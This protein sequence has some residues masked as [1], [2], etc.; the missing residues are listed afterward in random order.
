MTAT[1]ISPIGLVKSIN[2]LLTVL[3]MVNKD[4]KT[5]IIAV[6]PVISF[7]INPI[8]NRRTPANPVVAAV[9]AANIAIFFFDD[10]DKLLIHSASFVCH[11]VAFLII[12]ISAV[13]N[14]I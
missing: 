10:S 7:G 2:A 9:I 8:N 11:S 14:A 1:T 4:V 5:L 3:T 12:G 6:K 13:P